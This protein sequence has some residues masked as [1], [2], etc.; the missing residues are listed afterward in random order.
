MN[1]NI[2]NPEP[3]KFDED[4]DLESFSQ[5]N[6][7]YENKKYKGDLSNESKGFT[8]SNI[9]YRSNSTN[10]KGRR[11]INSIRKNSNSFF[12]R[13][14]NRNGFGLENKTR[15]K[16]RGFNKNNNITQYELDELKKNRYFNRTKNNFK[17]IAKDKGPKR[18]ES[19]IDQ[20]ISQLKHHYG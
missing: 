8:K 15:Y 12:G 11:P 18:D 13:T 19:K 1:N 2:N 5:L 14:L 7:L 9:S 4:D 20:L 6:N 3:N 16:T 10:S 17:I